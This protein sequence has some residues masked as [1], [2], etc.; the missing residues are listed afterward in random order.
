MS[1]E[2]A[3]PKFH[4]EVFI[5]PVPVAAVDKFV[6]EILFLWQVGFPTFIAGIG[7]P[8]ISTLIGTATVLHPLLSII[9]KLPVYVLA[10][11]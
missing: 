1:A 6:N 7:K 2:L 11:G 10:K 3:S 4:N 9:L 5:L 8:Q